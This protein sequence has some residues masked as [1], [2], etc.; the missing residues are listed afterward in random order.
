MKIIFETYFYLSINRLTISV[1]EKND[2]SKI[3]TKDFQFKN[4][5][6]EIDYLTIEKKKKLF[7][8]KSILAK[9]LVLF[10]IISNNEG[11]FFFI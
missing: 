5:L 11:Y 6:E 7:Q 3:Y 10:N 2:S 8:F 4:N 9:N 1:F